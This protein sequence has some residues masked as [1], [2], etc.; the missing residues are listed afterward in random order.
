M[1]AFIGLRSSERR[2]AK[3]HHKR[4]QSWNVCRYVGVFFILFFAFLCVI[5][6]VYAMTSFG[7]FRS[8]SDSVRFMVADCV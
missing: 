4:L 3:F 2:F 7:D 6:A 1:I 8:V 5:V